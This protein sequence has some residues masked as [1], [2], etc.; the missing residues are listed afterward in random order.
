MKRERF[1]ANALRFILKS[2]L[3]AL[4]FLHTKARIVHC[5]VKADNILCTSSI[6]KV[7]HDIAKKLGEQ[8][9]VMKIDK[10]DR[11]RI[12]KSIDLVDFVDDVSYDQILL[13]DFGEAEMEITVG[14]QKEW[15]PM[16]NDQYR[17]PEIHLEMEWGTPIDIWAVGILA[18][19]LFYNQLLF[20]GSSDR[21]S[22]TAE[23]FLSRM[24]A[25]LGPPPVEFLG[26]SKMTRCFWDEKGGWIGKASEPPVLWDWAVR[27]S[28]LE[29]DEK[30]AFT[31][32]LRS[33]LCWRPEDR[34]T[35]DQ[36]LADPW[37]N[38]DFESPTE[39]CALPLVDSALCLERAQSL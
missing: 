31:A 8:P 28:R 18:W 4:D 19:R 35:A 33:M 14:E 1:D 34:K 23:D 11:R 7:Y 37:L 9:A 6:D 25:V 38:E 26:R 39:K 22:T 3:A 10:R 12:Y 2:V 15:M 5:D 17:P 29:G 27:E 21:R 16:C 30:Q 20:G 32:F 36:L 24:H 13:G